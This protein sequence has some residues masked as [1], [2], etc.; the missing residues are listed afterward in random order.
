MHLTLLHPVPLSLDWLGLNFEVFSAESLLGR[1]KKK[2][3]GKMDPMHFSIATPKF[4]NAKACEIAAS[5]YFEPSTL[6]PN[7]RF[8]SNPLGLWFNLMLAQGITHEEELM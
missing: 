1:R 6:N 2:N 5:I 8:R 4:Y 3:V 7:L